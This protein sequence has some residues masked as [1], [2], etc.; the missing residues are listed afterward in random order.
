MIDLSILPDRPVAVLGLGR[1]G[2]AAARA[3]LSA[4]RPMLAWDDVA[5]QRTAAA[6]AGIPLTDLAA[7]DLSDV[8]MLVLSPGIPLD[9]PRPHPLVTR[10]RAAG[11]AIVGDV[12]LL[13][14]ACPAAD[15]V[16][17]TGTNGK[18][19]TT[20]LLGHILATA[21][22]ASAVGGNIGVPALALPPLATGGV[23]VLE[24]SSYQLGLTPSLR[25]RVAVLLNIS[26]DHLDRH[27]GIDGYVAAKR[28]IFA[29]Q[30]ADATAIVGADDATCR[31]IAAALHGDH[32][33]P[34]SGPRVIPI[35]GETVVPG[36]VYAHGGTLFDATA[37][38]EPRPVLTL[39][40]APALP[41]AHNA[42][43]AA[44]AWAA[45]RA[46][47]VDAATVA[48]A[49][50]SFPGLAHR[51]ELIATIDG[52]AYVNDSKAT[53]PDAAA[54]ALACYDAIYWIAGGRAKAGG[55]AAVR[56]YLDRIRHAYLIGEAAPDFAGELA[57]AVPVAISETLERA[58]AQAH[59]QA[60]R[61]GARAPV[62]LLSPAC[63][64][65]DQFRDFEARGDAFRALVEALGP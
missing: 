13:L 11:C 16:G 58:V 62:V 18:S 4:G 31:A 46:L 21:K 6:A 63:A 26:P 42:Q 29:G 35:S 52:V 45:A 28:R 40:E 54:R 12:E 9:H 36:G 56:P 23:Y 19:T 14:R 32:G 49:M 47:G 17:I 51:Q 39:A 60:H 41:G 43:N 34:K 7:R 48:A 1:S 64:S 15:V 61:N 37:G 65:F 30:G 27:G 55:L 24:L 50:R 25:C 3:L 22:V 20:A 44:A 2:L 59:A 38:G 5:A 10:A 57:S 8:A 53:N 33:G